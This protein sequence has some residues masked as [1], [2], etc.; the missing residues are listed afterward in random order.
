VEKLTRPEELRAAVVERAER[1]V[2][3]IKVMA[4]GGGITPGNAR[5]T[6]RSTILTS[7][8]PQVQGRVWPCCA[9]VRDGQDRDRRAGKL[10]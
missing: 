1:G 8:L 3:V 6:S 9:V 4:T 7:G 10:S 2:D 5:P